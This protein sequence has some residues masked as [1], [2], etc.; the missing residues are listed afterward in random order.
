M[1]IN[2]KGEV[3]R[4]YWPQMTKPSK[5]FG[6]KQQKSC[7]DAQIDQIERERVLKKFEQ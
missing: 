5:K 2:E 3:K 6:G 4:S 7:F 1:K